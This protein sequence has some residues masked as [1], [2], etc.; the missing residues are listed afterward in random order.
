MFKSINYSRVECEIC[1]AVTVIEPGRSFDGLECVCNVEEANQYNNI[2]VFTDGKS[3]VELLGEF[4]NGDVEVKHTDG[5]LSYRMNGKAFNNDFK[6]V[7]TPVE[8]DDYT[9]LSNEDL[10]EY[11]IGRGLNRAKQMKRETII[12][13]LKDL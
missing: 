8:M 13:K 9:V 3:E 7:G 1:N 12:K 2:L 5:T 10:I 6:E 11:A 4:A